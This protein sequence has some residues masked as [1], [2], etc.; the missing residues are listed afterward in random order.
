MAK[1]I[2][3][4]L[5]FLST[6]LQTASLFATKEP[7]PK[8]HQVLI[9][10]DCTAPPP[11]NFRITSIGGNF[12]ALAWTPAWLDAT[13]TL[14]VFKNDGLGSWIHLNTL[15]NVQDSSRTVDNL[16]S[17]T[18]YRFVIATNCGSGGPSELKGI[19][20]GIT[21]IV[22]L[23]IDGRRP[24]IPVSVDCENIPLNFDWVGFKIHYM[25]EGQRIENFFE[26]VVVDESSTN[27]NFFS[28]VEIR[29]TFRDNAIVA[30]D[31]F[32]FWPTCIEPV[33][34]DV[35]SSFKMARL[36]NGGPNKELIGWIDLHLNSSLKI[37]MC[38]DLDH[39]D[40]PWKTDY[41]F[42]ALIAP[43][44]SALPGCGDRS[45]VN[46]VIYQNLKAQ[47]PFEEVLNVFLPETFLNNG[48]CLFRLFN[49]K[50]QILMEQNIEVVSPQ[51]AFPM[52][53]LIPG[54]YM[55]QIES[56]GEIQI[57]KVVKT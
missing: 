49:L 44:A 14:E 55:L 39:Q 7:I 26:F 50:G 12:I 37:S 5:L 27:N 31:P 32:D 23:V 30:I 54:I 15:H 47:N 28:K 40:L 57:A 9:G 53:S 19:I 4:A 1:K 8:V 24:A 6:F 11:T 29:R 48:R 34:F 20:D 17:G 56:E 16:E 35:G 51:V 3:F 10:S 41:V 43:K 36:I 38:P 52:E 18:E 33:R 2:L 46:A 21:L 42:S 13:H 22:D 45:E 25:L